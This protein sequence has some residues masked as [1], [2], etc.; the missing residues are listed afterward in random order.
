MT[1]E[2]S[3][4][5]NAPVEKVYKVLTSEKGWDSWFTNGTGIDLKIGGYIK[6]KWSEFGPY[7]ITANR[8][9]L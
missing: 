3:T 5:I 6:L 9:L 4:Y 7:N 2:H 1:I 8:L